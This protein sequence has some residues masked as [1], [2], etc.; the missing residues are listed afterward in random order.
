MAEKAT[1]KIHELSINDALDLGGILAAGG[2]TGQAGAALSQL[3]RDEGGAEG[4]ALGALTQLVMGAL[5]NRATRDDM[6]G[7][8]FALWKTT[9][10]EQAAEDDLDIAGRLKPRYVNGE[11]EKGTVYYRK[12]KRF[13]DLPPSALVG[14]AGAIYESDGFT[15]FLELLK[16]ELPTSSTEPQTQSNGTTPSSIKT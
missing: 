5:A 16:T 15:D 6:R 1:Y 2:L 4:A 11:P 10:D 13:H 9:E 12:L 8:L 3:G 7:F 14:L